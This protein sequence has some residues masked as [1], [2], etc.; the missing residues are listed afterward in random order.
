MAKLLLAI[1]PGWKK[2]TKEKRCSGIFGGVGIKQQHGLP[3]IFLACNN[4]QSFPGSYLTLSEDLLTPLSHTRAQA[5]STLLHNL[6]KVSVRLCTRSHTLA[7][8]QTPT[9]AS[10]GRSVCAFWGLL[11]FAVRLNSGSLL[12]HLVVRPSAWAIFSSP[13][14]VGLYNLASGRQN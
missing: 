8:C 9:N 5:E 4:L 10:L 3:W 11:S 12:L 1:L 7:L 13:I 14:V 6:L 2:T